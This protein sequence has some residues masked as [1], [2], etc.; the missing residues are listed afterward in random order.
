MTTSLASL[1][2]CGALLAINLLF[3]ML[4]GFAGVGKV[5]QGLPPWFGDKFGQTLLASF[6]GLTATFWL[7]TLEELLALALAS[8]ALLRGEFLERRPAIWLALSL[9]WSLFVFVQLALGQWLTADYNG[10]AQIFAYFSGT[11]IALHYVTRSTAAR[12]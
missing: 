10:A 1:P 5:A 9:A 8:V 7:L 12:Q 3:L 2:R 4:W 11:L 6:P